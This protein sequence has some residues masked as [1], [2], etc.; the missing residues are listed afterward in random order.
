MSSAEWRGRLLRLDGTGEGAR[1][2]GE[3]GGPRVDA[4]L[5]RSRERVARLAV[6]QACR[7]LR[8][9]PARA[10]G[11]RRATIRQARERLRRL[12]E[13]RGRGIEEFERQPIAQA[14]RAAL[15][16]A[17]KAEHALIE[18]SREH[19]HALHDLRD[20]ASGD[21]TQAE[22][23]AKV[24]PRLR[25]TSASRTLYIGRADLKWRAR[26]RSRSRRSDSTS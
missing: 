24:E 25:D 16:D 26:S 7:R 13:T 1:R 20:V 17:S 21:E 10:R 15:A 5:R 4:A 23:F 9:A 18:A 12:D 8:G 14:M 2:R 3:D 11:R 19:A 6:P 22:A